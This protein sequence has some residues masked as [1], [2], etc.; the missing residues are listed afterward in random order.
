[1]TSTVSA[2]IAVERDA[3]FRIGW[4]ILLGAAALMTLN[5][6]VLT[7]VLRQPVLFIGFAAF[8]LYALVVIA[9]PFR[10]HE[11]W[12][13]YSTWILPVGLAAPGFTDPN[14]AI[15]YYAIA[16]AC[17]VGLLLTR[18]GFFTAERWGPAGTPPRQNSTENREG[19]SL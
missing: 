16:A 18:R 13:W 12:A 9:I 19:A 6:A 5:H 17:V 3:R 11:R 1:M 4:I 15:F 7:F 8:N 10:R 14:I 2:P